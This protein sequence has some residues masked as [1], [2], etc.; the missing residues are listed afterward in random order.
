MVKCSGRRNGSEVSI[1]LCGQA[2]QGIQ[3]VEFLLTRILKVAGYHVFATKE[4]ELTGSGI[5]PR[6]IPGFGPGL[7]AV[8]SDEHDV[9]VHRYGGCCVSCVKI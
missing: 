4:Y 2:G 7:V 3:T 1:V 8:D 9:E 6:G 5:S